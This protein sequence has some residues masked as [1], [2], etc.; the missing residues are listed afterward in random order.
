MSGVRVKGAKAAAQKAARSF[1]LGLPVPPS[2]TREQ[3]K[4][5]AWTVRYHRGVEPKTPDSSFSRMQEEQQT[6]VRALAGA[7]R[8]ARGLR[9]CGIQDG[10]GFR[11]EKSSAAV[12]LHVPGLM[13]SAE[14]AARLAS[15]K[16]L[17][18]SYLGKPIILK[19]AQKIEKV[20]E[21]PS[22]AQHDFLISA[23]SD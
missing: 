17:L 7:I 12:I 13:D 18:D 19:P 8:L 6:N 9:K 11:V 23:A 10:T 2:W 16:H 20:V 3:W 21:L 14:T 5:L 1:L 4:L 22:P 15:A